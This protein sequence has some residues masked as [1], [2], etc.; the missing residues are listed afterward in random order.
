MIC[1]ILPFDNNDIGD[2]SLH[3]LMQQRRHFIRN[4]GLLA[5]GAILGKRAFA[6]P[7]SQQV[8][9]NKTCFGII[10]DLHHLQFGQNEE[11]RLKGFMDAVMDKSPEFIVQCG[12]FC[13][14]EKS[15]GIM[16]EWNRFKGPKY[17]VLGNHDMDVCSKETIM[18]L[19][20]ME[21]RYYSFDRDGFHYIV[22]DRN[23]LRKADGTLLDYDRSNWG[24]VASPGR[25]FT[26]QAQLE[27]LKQDLAKAQDPVIVFMHQPV[28]LSDFFQEIGNADDILKIFD[29]ANLNASKNGKAA[30]VAAVFMG[31]DHDDRYGERNGV[32]YFILNSATYVY[33]ND[34]A[35]FYRD[36]LYAF[37]TLD[38][39]GKMVVEG[40]TSV[41]RTPPPDSVI[42]QF[43][44]RI[45]DHTLPLFPIQT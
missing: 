27:W 38:P 28:F 1:P 35:Y 23:F 9:A 16:A 4:L 39:K 41:Y 10:S 6:I 2:R 22:M 14:P 18:K 33:T 20:G 37:V 40:R 13:R 5:G 34:Q 24:P 8:H 45:S 29:E 11:A 26:D 43:P 12:D 25:S 44:T 19:W 36:P 7:M 21:E 17:H 42:A 32:H 30:R 15:E 3:L 31:H